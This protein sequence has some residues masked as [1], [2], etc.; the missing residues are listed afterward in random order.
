ME[1]I[2]APPTL[3]YTFFYTFYISYNVGSDGGVRWGSVTLSTCSANRSDDQIDE[4]TSLFTYELISGCN[5]TRSDRYKSV[6]T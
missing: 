3:L 5:A 6:F 1:S 4:D 2:E